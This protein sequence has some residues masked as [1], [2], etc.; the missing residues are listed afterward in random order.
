MIT[1]LGRAIE[2]GGRTSSRTTVLGQHR[3]CSCI[4]PPRARRD[5]NA[6]QE[7]IH[8]AID[9]GQLCNADWNRIAERPST[10]IAH[11]TVSE[12]ASMA[13]VS[14][15]IPNGSPTMLSAH[16]QTLTRIQAVY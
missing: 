15:E 12:R 1:S 6:G 8:R 13:H 10:L 7:R 11:T 14:R 16:R 2:R 3:N 5:L 9:Y 4:R